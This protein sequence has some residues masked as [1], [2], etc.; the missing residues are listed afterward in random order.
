MQRKE[1]EV[2]TRE[3][4]TDTTNAAEQQM[5]APPVDVK[6]GQPAKVK[7]DNEKLDPNKRLSIAEDPDGKKNAKLRPAAKKS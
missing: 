6:T 3:T 7:W 1:T 5:V 2:A 4:A